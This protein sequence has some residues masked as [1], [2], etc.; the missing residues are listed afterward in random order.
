MG[1]SKISQTVEEILLDM[2]VNNR[3]PVYYVIYKLLTTCLI[4]PVTC[5]NAERSPSVRKREKTSLR[6][7]MLNSRL[8][9][10]TLVQTYKNVVLDH[11]EIVDIYVNMPPAKKSEPE[12]PGPLVMNVAASDMDMDQDR[13]DEDTVCDLFDDG[14]ITTLDRYTTLDPSGILFS[15]YCR[16]PRR[17]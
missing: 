3:I 8:S 15:C 17:A 12:I 13:T 2:K 1:K 11:N 7:S 14:T 5:A 16:K 6:A 4:V 9:D 10:L